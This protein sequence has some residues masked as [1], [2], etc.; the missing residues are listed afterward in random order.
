MKRIGKV[1]VIGSD[2]LHRTG[3][4]VSIG[5]ISTSGIRISVVVDEPTSTR[6]LWPPCTPRTDSTPRPKPRSTR[7]P[8][9][10]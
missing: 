9:D 5:M 3:A 4:G 8:A 1:S 2:L 6:A 7:V 10:D